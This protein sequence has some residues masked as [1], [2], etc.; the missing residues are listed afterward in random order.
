MD[1]CETTVI[2]VLHPENPSG[3]HSVTVEV[4]CTTVVET[5]D[6]PVVV[7]D[8]GVTDEAVV[9][10]DAVVGVDDG[11]AVSDSVELVVVEATT[12]VVLHPILKTPKMPLHS[13]TVED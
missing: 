11:G 9:S 10:V 6:E 7:G 1:V 8:E 12:V 13:V 2:D 4:D 5:T 3:P